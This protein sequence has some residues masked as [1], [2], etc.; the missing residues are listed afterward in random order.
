MPRAGDVTVSRGPRVRITRRKFLKF[1]LM[2]GAALALPFGTSGC[3]S[4]IHEGSTGN[5]LPSKVQLPKPFGVLLPIPAVAKP[6]RTDD[7]TDYY[8]IAQKVGRAKIL[9]G[10]ETEVWGYD[11]IFPGPTIEARSGRRVI[12]RQINQLPVPVS[13]H[14]HGGRTPPR[15]T[16][17]PPT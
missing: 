7:T 6:V 10:L 3:S 2:G 15:A 12:I 14:L 4:E 17:T 11:A 5:L 8:E 16:A 9:P 1:G 13:T